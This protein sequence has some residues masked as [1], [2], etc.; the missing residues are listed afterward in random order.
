MR[1]AI[2]TAKPSK[3]GFSEQ[4]LHPKGLHFGPANWLQVSCHQ[5]SKDIPTILQASAI[6]SDIKP[7]QACCLPCQAAT[8]YGRAVL[9]SCCAYIGKHQHCMSCEHSD[10]A[11][12]S[13]QPG[14]RAVKTVAKKDMQHKSYS[15]VDKHTFN[16]CRSCLTPGSSSRPTPA[17]SAFAM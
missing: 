14:Q 3:E 13:T 15:E 16:S 11:W 5:A 1:V 8:E 12:L 4:M 17:L 10:D 9:C 7:C 6:A 2:V